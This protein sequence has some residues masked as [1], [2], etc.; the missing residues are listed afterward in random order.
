[1]SVLLVTYDLRK[2]GQDYTSL[3]EAIKSYPNCHGLE[4]VWFIQSTKKA[5]AIRDHLKR[6]IDS[7]DRLFVS[8]VEHDWAS[9]N[10]PCAD[11]INS[12]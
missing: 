8:S 2:P 10:V 11:W 9:W 4:S 3:Y 5:E 12:H 6:Y 7:N 1:M